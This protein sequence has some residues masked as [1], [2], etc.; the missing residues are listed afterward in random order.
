MSNPYKALIAIS[1][2]KG[3]VGKS[4][5]AANLACALAQQ[6]LRIGLLDAD[7]YG[8]SIPLIMGATSL[9]E[10]RDGKLIPVMCH[11]VQTMSIGYLIANQDTA[12]AWRGPMVSRALQQLLEE[13]LWDNLD[14]LFLDLPPGTGDIQLTMAQKM[15]V[16]G[17]VI[18]STPQ[19]V[20]LIDVE[21]GANLFAKVHVPLLGI[22]ENMAMHHC[23]ACGHEEAIFGSGGAAGFAERHQIP[24]L[25]QI[26]LERAICSDS[27]NGIP[28]V[29]ATPDSS[30]ARAY[31]GAA[32]QFQASF[33]RHVQNN[34]VKSPEICIT[35]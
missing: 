27:D 21:K 15:K 14:I 11:N 33:A 30:A 34:P 16:D 35:V 5:V 26:P 8:P 18:V 7:I 4:T 2:T 1:S 23:S 31:Q 20:A 22:I 25:A 6:G 9:P 3:G 28:T 19:E 29:V 12:M 10:S 17:A 32:L 24:V 13:T